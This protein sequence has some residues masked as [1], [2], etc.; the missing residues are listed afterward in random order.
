MKLTE[1][2]SFETVLSEGATMQPDYSTV[3]TTDFDALWDEMFAASQDFLEALA[4]QTHAEYLAGL[5]EDFD[6]DTDPDLQ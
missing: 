3:S 1:G 2:Y 6:P 5:T 4:D